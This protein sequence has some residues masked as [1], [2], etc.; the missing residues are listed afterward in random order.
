MCQYILDDYLRSDQGAYCSVFVTQPRRISATSVA[1]RVAS[2]RGE[3]LGESA[4]YSVRFESCLPRPYGSI[5]FCT[6]GVLL[7]RLERGLRGISHIIVD[8]IHE[9]DVNTDF[10]LVV[11]RDMTLRHPELRVILMSA[12]IDTS[13]FSRYFGDCPVVEIPGNVHPVE[14]HY[15]EDCVQMLGFRPVPDASKNKNGRDEDKATG[16]ED[17]NLNLQVRLYSS[18]ATFFFFF[19]LVFFLVFFFGPRAA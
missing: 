11:L 13:L 5:L 7:R 19:F 6:V 1:D 9:R 8:E 18:T 15:L 3:E 10:L 12:T 17:G 16:D 14:I 4:G 2:E